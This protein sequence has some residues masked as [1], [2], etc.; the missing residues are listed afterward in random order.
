[1]V[2]P[3]I[4]E[5][6]QRLVESDRAGAVITF[7]AGP[8]VGSKAV[9]DVDGDV[10]AGALP[11]Q[12][13][14]PVLSDAAV[15]IDRE[16]SATLGYDVDEIFYEVLA[17]RPTLFVFGA[18]HIA[19]ELVTHAGLLGYR[20]VVADPR[21]AFVTATRF[22]TADE[23]RVGWPEAVCDQTTFDRRTFVVVLTH[24]RR[25]EDP[26]WPLVLPSPA[27]YIGAMGSEK[28]A[29]RRRERLLRDGFTTAQVDRIHGPVGLKIGSRTAGETAIAIIGEMIG[30]RYA[31]NDP[32]ELIGIPLRV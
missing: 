6:T 14:D 4:F 12:L 18:V 16:Q 20:T 1:V 15:L 3:T 29:A 24:D 7:I 21:P 13:V 17:P 28:T 9:V 5:A 2:S 30:A 27:R 22:P 32:P 26:L 25:F 11:D 8:H 19:Q 31:I 23:L 10:L